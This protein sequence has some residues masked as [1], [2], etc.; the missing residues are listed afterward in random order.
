MLPKD[1]ENLDV[2]GAHREGEVS[3]LIG[4]GTQADSECV[5]SIWGPCGL[6]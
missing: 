6:A 5:G 3:W 1:F 4:S 2:P